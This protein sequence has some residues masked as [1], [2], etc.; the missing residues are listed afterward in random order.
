MRPGPAESALSQPPRAVSRGHV[1]DSK[2]ARWHQGWARK[3]LKLPPLPSSHGEYHFLCQCTNSLKSHNLLKMEIGNLN[4]PV[5]IKEIELVIKN[6]LE[7][8]SPGPHCFIREFYQLFKEELTLSL[9]ENT[10]IRSTSQFTSRS[11]HYPD[12]KPRKREY[13]KRQLQTNT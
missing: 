13:Q 4:S 9:P 11:S 12:A 7:K 5:T 10:I 8:K 6:F 1:E 2:A 3:K